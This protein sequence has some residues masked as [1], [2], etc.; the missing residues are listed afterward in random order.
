MAKR[1]S[2][3]D[4]A[5]DPFGSGNQPDV[6]SSWLSADSS[7]YGDLSQADSKAE[8]TRI[9]EFNIFTIHPDPLQPR[10]VLP[11]VLREMWNGKPESIGDIFVEWVRIISEEERGGDEFQF[12]AHMQEQEIDGDDYVPKSLELALLEVIKLAVSIR[13]DGLTNPITVVEVP[14]GL[15]IETGERRWLAYHL[16]HAF[17]DDPQNQWQQI[18]A[19]KVEALDVWRQAS[20]N[21]AR[22][23][24]NATG[25]ARQFAILM[26]DLWSRN[27][28]RFEPFEAYEAEQ[29]YYAQVSELSPPHGKS[30][31]ILNAM[32]FQNRNAISRYRK[33]LT[34]DNDIW[35]LAD[36]SN[37]P[38]SILRRMIGKGFQESI[39]IFQSWASGQ[40]A[41]I[42]NVTS[43]D[44]SPK[45][46]NIS[47]TKKSPPPTLLSDPAI[48]Q[49]DRLFSRE[50]HHSLSLSIK[51]LA[52]LRSGV[53]QAKS[54]TKQQI[55]QLV[56]DLRN[57]LDDVEGSIE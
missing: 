15:R 20:E 33:L 27:G 13:R 12:E 23:N 5:A 14:D 38:E 7:I 26:M 1:K 47:Q 51:E 46:P 16:L 21:N 29:H 9:R 36:D 48:R 18:P 30:N 57:F 4:N 50:A 3:K 2:F 39:A 53:G 40:S 42:P 10:R 25:R 44:I 35:L 52:S 45:P 17:S 11:S 43:G 31:V 32:G 34:L 49:G 6:D 24:L 55:Q 54:Q 19:R 56:N 22:Q 8:R 37:C 41:D 28:K